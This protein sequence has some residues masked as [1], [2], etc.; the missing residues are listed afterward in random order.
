M[1]LN[2]KYL[3]TLSDSDFQVQGISKPIAHFL[4]RLS[5]WDYSIPLATQ[6]TI[7][8]QPE[9]NEEGNS[10]GLFS[11]IKEY[12][13]VDI[14]NFYIPISI[15]TRILNNKSQ[16]N[17]DGLGLYYAQSIKMPRES[18]TVNSAGIVGTGG[19]LKGI[20]GGDRLD[21]SSRNLEIEF[22]E[23]NIDFTDG[24][25]RPWIICAA[26]RGLINTGKRNSIKSSIFISEFTRQRNNGD[27]KPIRKIHTFKGCVPTSVAERTLKYDKE[28]IEAPVNS[29]T[30]IYENYSY[31]IDPR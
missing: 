7:V 16:P 3:E 27:L 25:I 8:I 12:T 9:A 14:S 5:E 1:Q 29:V 31:V 24:L 17:M 21:M 6:W 20:V 19:F 2:A 18:F 26:Y 10:E 11:L 23:T 30:W 22:L 28:P 13:Q 4:D 15:Q